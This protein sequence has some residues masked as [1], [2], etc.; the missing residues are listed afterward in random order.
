MSVN[1]YHQK[2]KA[3]SAFVAGRKRRYCQNRNKNLWMAAELPMNVSPGDW[4]IF[5]QVQV[6]VQVQHVP[7]GSL[8]EQLSSLQ[9]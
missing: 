3:F 5:L 4:D 7:P 1:Y 9:R 6:Q 2:G 8:L